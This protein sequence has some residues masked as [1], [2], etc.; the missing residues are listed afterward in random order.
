MKMGS[1]SSSSSSTRVTSG[2][3][4]CHGS[5]S[6]S[7]HSINSSDMSDLPWKTHFNMED[8]HFYPQL[9]TFSDPLTSTAWFYRGEARL[10]HV[11]KHPP[12]SSPAGLRPTIDSTHM[13]QSGNRGRGL[14][15]PADTKTNSFQMNVLIIRYRKRRRLVLPF[16]ISCGFM[17]GHTGT[18][19]W[20]VPS[21][22][23]KTCGSIITAVLWKSMSCLWRNSS[24]RCS[25]QRSLNPALLDLR[26]CCQWHGWWFF[27][28]MF[29]GY[30]V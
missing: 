15:W 20:R 28:E 3:G 21:V 18:G 23:V 16:R 13:D 27:K 12:Q 14:H 9:K 8:G 19:R 26:R 1:S 7:S 24:Q 30:K 17:D 2:A 10:N 11:W 5:N 25:L 22:R 6:S 4:L 29:R